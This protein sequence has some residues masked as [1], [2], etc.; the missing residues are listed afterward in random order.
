MA[1]EKGALALKSETSL[2][3]MPMPLEDLVKDAQLGGE[4]G[5]KD[6][7]IPYLY[8]L[9]TNSP[10]CN[11]DSEKYIEGARAGMFLL[12]V[13]DKVFEGRDKGITVVPC[14]YERKIMEWIQREEGGGLVGSYEAEHPIM[15][16]AKPNEKGQMILPNGHMLMD[17]A[18][19][20]VL[21]YDESDKTWVQC[22]MP[23]KS[24]GLKVSRKL[25]SI[26]KKSLIP[27][28]QNKAPRFL[29]QYNLK[30]IKEQKDT[31]IWS[32]PVFEQLGIV[33]KEVYDAAKAYSII[34][35]QNLLARAPET[36]GHVESNII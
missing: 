20:Y 25:N 4:V 19:H 18:Y 24:T 34:A 22:I 33:S 6:I 27:G 15:R 30:T 13:M 17:T 14:Y 1:D 21:A 9:Q 23:M 5:L 35:S 2:A 31:N 29:F 28:T 7:A 11:E 8:I 12:T 10:Q 32:S 26:V 36:N 16:D 3:N